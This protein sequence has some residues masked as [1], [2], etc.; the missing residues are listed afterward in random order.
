MG[1]AYNAKDARVAKLAVSSVDEGSQAATRGVQVGDVL[2]DVGGVSVAGKDK[3][4]VLAMIS[5]ASRPVTLRLT[6]V[7]DM[8]ESKV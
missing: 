4:Q 3:A 5:A 2:V 8:E 6:V 1:I 7:H